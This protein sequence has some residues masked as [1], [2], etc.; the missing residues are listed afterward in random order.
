MRTS[1]LVISLVILFAANGCG[2]SSGGSTGTA[3]AKG[4]AGSLGTAGN[5]TAGSTGTAGG[6][7]AG[8]GT[9]GAGDGG[10]AGATGGAAGT[11]DGGNTDADGGGTAG[12]PAAC[13]TSTSASIG[14]ACNTLDPAGPCVTSTL[15]TGTPP[16]PGG[17]PIQ[18]GTYDL[19]SLVVYPTADA[20]VPQ[21]GSDPRRGAIAFPAVTTGSF[22][23]QMTESSG[24]TFDR[25]AGTVVAAGTQVTFAP[26][27]P[28][29]GDAGNSGGSAGYTA[30]ATT[31]TLFD[32][33]DDGNLRLNL[34]TKR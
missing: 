14:D 25:Q 12:A 18:G 19:T 20:G 6:G 16:I 10:T 34:Y 1:T 30:T 28:P 13:G 32:T 21:V 22:V 27:C 3:G 11:V 17:G 33:G 15:G 8:S 24:T 4:T 5:S 31:F 29:R 23:I 7:T 9:A 26:T 2:S